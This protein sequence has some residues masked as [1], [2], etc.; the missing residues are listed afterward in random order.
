MS[1]EARM[2]AILNG[3]TFDSYAELK[4]ASPEE[5]LEAT[6]LYYSEEPNPEYVK[7]MRAGFALAR[8]GGWQY[9]APAWLRWLR[10]HPL[11]PREENRGNQEE[12]CLKEN[13]ERK[14]L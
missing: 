2:R 1:E 10:D 11:P 9:V 4:Q 13:F 14:I 6:C 7:G 3:P 5:L 8:P 12:D